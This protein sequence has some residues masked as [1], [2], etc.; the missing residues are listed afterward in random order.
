[1]LLTY[2]YFV[3]AIKQSISSQHGRAS[4]A[5][6]QRTLPSPPDKYRQVTWSRCHVIPTTNSV[7]LIRCSVLLIPNTVSEVNLGRCLLVYV[8]CS[9]FIMFYRVYW[10][11]TGV[12]HRLV[13]GAYFMASNGELYR[14]NDRRHLAWISFL[15]HNLHNKN[16]EVAHHIIHTHHLNLKYNSHC[17]ILCLKHSPRSAALSCAAHRKRRSARSSDTRWSPECHL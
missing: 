12:Y 8:S 13:Y 11:A 4:C 2:L 3:Y 14:K 16:K 15:F 17:Y 5:P 7:T 9:Y 1:M 10:S 6:R